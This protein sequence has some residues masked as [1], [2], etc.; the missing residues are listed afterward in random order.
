MMARPTPSAPSSPSQDAAPL[1][2]VRDLHVEFRTFDGVAE[3][4]LAHLVAEL[5]LLAGGDFGVESERAGLFV[6]HILT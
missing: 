5:A 3:V 2:S 6:G 4:G 1:L